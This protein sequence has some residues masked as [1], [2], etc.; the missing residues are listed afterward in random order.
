MSPLQCVLNYYAFNISINSEGI[1]LTMPLSIQFTDQQTILVH[2][3]FLKIVTPKY[4]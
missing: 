3:I 4:K 1:I 2:T